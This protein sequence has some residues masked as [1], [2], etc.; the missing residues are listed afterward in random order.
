L[1]HA[2]PFEVESRKAS[3]PHAVLATRVAGRYRIESELGRGG[4][5]AVY[6]AFDEGAERVVALKML[7]VATGKLGAL[8]EREYATLAKLAHPRV[9]EVYD[10]GHT[11]DGARYYTME[12]LAGED[13]LATSPLHWVRACEYLRD[14]CTSLSLLHA[15]CL[16]HRDVNPRNVRLDGMGRAKLLDFGALAPFGI[17]SELVGTPS[18]MAPEALRGQALD[19]RTDLFSLGAVAYWSLTGVLPYRIRRLAEAEDAWRVPPAAPSQHVPAIPKALDELILALL[20]IDPLGRPMSAADVIDRLSAIALFDDELLSGVAESHL[21]SAALVGREPEQAAA[22]QLVARTLRGR[23]GLMIFEGDAGTGRTRMLAELAVAAQLAGLATLRIAGR[24]HRQPDGVLLGL[25]RALRHAAPEQTRASLPGHL[26]ELGPLL[27]R[28]RMDAASQVTPTAEDPSCEPKERAMRLQAALTS[29]IVEVAAQRPL[30]ISI[31]D[32][33][34]LHP[35]SAGVLPLLAHAAQE[36]RLM[37]C[38]T[39]LREGSAAPG[40]EQL[41]WM[42]SVVTLKALD[43]VAVERLVHS[44]FGDVPH[45]T[46]LAQWLATSGHGNPG[47]LLTLLRDLVARRVI[48]YAGG[49]WVLPVQLGEAIQA[50]DSP[51]L[52]TARLARVG[53]EALSLAELLAVHSG[54]LPEAICLRLL[55]AEPRR[56][57]DALAQLTHEKLVAGSPDGYRLVQESVRALLLA[58]LPSAAQ[59]ALHLTVGNA[60]RTASSDGLSAMR[61]GRMQ[62]LNTAEIGAGVSAGLHFLCGGDEALGTAL[63][64]AGA[65][66]LTKR[67]EGLTGSLADLEA[68]V[69]IYKARGRGRGVYG[70]LMTALTL[71][72]TYTDWRLSY[73]Y[74]DELLDILAELAGIKA[75]RRLE[76]YLGGHLALIVCFVFSF[77]IYRLFPKRRIAD[78]F[79]EVL[80]GLMG[81]GSAVLGVCTVLQD[82]ERALSIA[83][84]LSPLRF[85]PRNHPV[86][87]VHEFQLSLVDHALGRYEECRRKAGAAL[88]YVQSEVAAKK[89][90]EDAR[91]QL[92]AGI[93]I[94]LGQLDALRTDASGLETLAAIERLSTSTSRQMRAGTLA[95]FH[96]H[97]GERD[98]FIRSIEEMDRMAAQAGAIWRNDMQVLRMLWTTY[99][100][101][102]DVM[103]LKRAVQQLDTLAAE[104]P[105]VARLRD[106]VDACY[107]AERGMAAEALTRHRHVFEAL[108]NEPGVRTIQYLGAYA[109]ILRKAGEPER[110]KQVCEAAIAKLTGL[111][112]G[113]TMLT[114]GVRLELPLALAALGEHAR[115]AALLDV[116]LAEQEQHDN[117]LIHGL[118]HGARA[119][120]SLLQHDWAEAERQLAAMGE[121]FRDTQH[122]ALFAQYQRLADRARTG[123][124]GLDSRKHQSVREPQSQPFSAPLSEPARHSDQELAPAAPPELGLLHVLGRTSTKPAPLSP[125]AAVRVEEPTQRPSKH[126]AQRFVA[127]TPSNTN[128]SR[129]LAAYALT[130]IVEDAAEAP[131]ALPAAGEET[132]D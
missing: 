57:L 46:R 73:R 74:G 96:G 59:Q 25:L 75:A 16:V 131:E 4:M 42:G 101:C 18:C 130:T 108:T 112:L 77:L 87:M 43:L 86:R 40:V 91:L 37:V 47:Q 23:G 35:S 79:R 22:A 107:L 6:R 82:R 19:A 33:H 72:G 109:R 20:S 80:L 29:L 38:A 126:S 85:F 99:A 67:G 68:A 106:A 127:A 27:E 78:S 9:I 30:L 58:R 14:V 114:Y 83:A 122:P 98:A 32:A 56:V 50:Q 7:R 12:L 8:F 103:S 13:L 117:P 94:L 64:R 2:G 45:R 60:L 123:K 88:A 132:S 70:A 10:Y 26:T 54:T 102:E 69:A 129:A 84:L 125:P 62:G 44:I 93:Y 36:G 5:G 113:F 11:E 65:I 3:T 63:L 116:L 118:T 49:A 34:L 81:I 105:S 17:A 124:L 76:R 120:L 1:D 95:A 21:S 15:Q 55:P 90:R 66:E 53:P 104:A 89:L 111:E 121:W 52:A 128:A 48:R 39:R 24:E 100:L 51:A 115:A 61:A 110:A 97:R 41:R 92:E 119:E 71:A 28:S 31:D